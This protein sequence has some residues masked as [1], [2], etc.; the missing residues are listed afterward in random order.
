MVSGRRR[1][2]QD[3][4]GRAF[5][6]PLTKETHIMK[7][8]KDNA[9]ATI[10]GSMRTAEEMVTTGGGAIDAVSA[11]QKLAGAAGVKAALGLFKTENDALDANNKKKANLHLQ[12]TQ[13]EADE[14]TLMRHWG[15]RRVG[16]IHE[17]NVECDGSKENIQAFNLPV[18]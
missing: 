7:P 14:V 1:R 5:I 12:L 10:A 2:G 15:L 8:K 4:P 16:L 3:G 9:R 11:S 17:V 6:V 18:V 13:A